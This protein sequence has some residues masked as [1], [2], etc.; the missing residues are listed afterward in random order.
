MTSGTVDVRTPGVV[1]PGDEHFSEEM[2]AEMA[3]G[4]AAHLALPRKAT[5]VQIVEARVKAIHAYREA[6]IRIR[7]P[8][9]SMR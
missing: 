9:G 2:R 1:Y 4:D 3:V 5:A 6:C 7:M 8:D